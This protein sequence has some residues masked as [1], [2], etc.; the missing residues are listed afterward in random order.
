MS[1]EAP[2]QTL[3]LLSDL[4]LFVFNDGL[5]EDIQ[6]ACRS[7]HALA[8]KAASD[9]Y[10]P[11]AENNAWFDRYV[12]IMGALGWVAIKTEVRNLTQGSMHLEL[13]DLIAKGLE[14]GYEM[15]TGNVKKG[16]ADLGSAIIDAVSKSGKTELLDIRTR[17]DDRK[18][19]S[20]GKCDQSTGGQVAMLVSLVVDDE[21]PK[22]SGKSL[23]ANWERSGMTTY[24][25]GAGFSFSRRTYDRARESIEARI[26]ARSLQVLAT[27]PVV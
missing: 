19:M 11:L 18:V 27:I 7:C 20:L 13:G 24:A 14:A 22:K 2:N 17:E 1:T 21:I 16:L 9:Q 23:F 5:S 8:L 10:H 12:E 6:E 25:C 3:Q 4:N 15:A 26:D